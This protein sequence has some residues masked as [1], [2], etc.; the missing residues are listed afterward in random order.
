MQ[1]S[2][3]T[4]I[5][6]VKMNAAIGHCKRMPPAYYD[7]ETHPYYFPAT[8]RDEWCGEHKKRRTEG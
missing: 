1:E 4:C 2:C 6:W 8:P 7:D 3:K 5:F